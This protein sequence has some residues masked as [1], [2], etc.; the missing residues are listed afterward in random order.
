MTKVSLQYHEEKRTLL[1]NDAGSLGYL[2]KKIV[3]LGTYFTECAH[4]NSRWV[5]M[6]KLIE[7]N[8]ENVL[9]TFRQGVLKSSQ[10][11][12][13]I[14]K[15]HVSRKR[16]KLGTLFYQKMALSKRNKPKK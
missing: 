3:D 8:M 9:Q 1:T 16:R 6:I 7:N 11:A 2:N 10:K 5:K 14:R 4:I 13:T 15:R 12:L